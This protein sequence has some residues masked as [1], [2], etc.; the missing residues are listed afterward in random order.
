MAT[1]MNTSLKPTFGIK[2]EKYVSENLEGFLTAVEKPSSRKLYN[3]NNLNARTRKSE[4]YTKSLRTWKIRISL[5]SDRQNQFHKSHLNWRLQTVGLWPPFKGGRHRSTPKGSIPVWRCE[6]VTRKSE[7]GVVSSRRK[8][9]E[10]I[11]SNASDPIS[12]IT[13]KIPQENQQERVIPNQVGNTREK[14]YRNVF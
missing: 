3:A 5:F 4:K 10:A 1:G 9:C 13:D 12:K 8:F 14:L 7:N 2:T 6:W 11:T